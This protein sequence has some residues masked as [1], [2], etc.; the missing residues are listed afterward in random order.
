MVNKDKKYV[1]AYEGETLFELP[2][3]VADTVCEM[4]QKLGLSN[5]S[6][7]YAI[8]HH[9]ICKCSNLDIPLKFEYVSCL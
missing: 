7:R 4:E 5:G 9:S 2:V 6:V 3:F 1:V 8:S